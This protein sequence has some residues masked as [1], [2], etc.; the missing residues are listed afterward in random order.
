[1]TA[2]T[3]LTGRERITWNVLSSWAGHSVFIAAGFI[4]P[5][6][7]DERLGQQRLG[8]WDFAWSCVAYF[9]LVQG[10]VVSSINRYV[11][12][13]RAAGDTA[14]VNRVVS[15]VECVLTV[16]AGI[17]VILS[18]ATALLI[19][20]LWTGR[21][22][23]Y[24]VDAQWAVFLL[25]LGVALEVWTAGYAGVLTGCHRW[26]LHNGIH[27]FTC[28]LTTGGM[29]VAVLLDGGLPA[30]AAAHVLGEMV[31]RLMRV[32]LAY[33][34]FP[35]LHVRPHL[36]DWATAREMLHFGS[37]SFIP[38]IGDLL[39][40][41]TISVLILS[42]IGTAALAVFSRPR[43]LVRQV[44]TLV[45]KLAYVLAPT[46]SSLQAAARLDDLRDLFIRSTRYGVYIALPM[47]LVLTILGAPLLYVWMGQHYAYGLLLT[48][49]A[50]GGLATITQE[51]VINFL[52]GLNAHG[53]PGLANMAASLG[54]VG[55]AALAIGPLHLG[56]IGA[57]LA[58]SLPQSFV[59]GVY[60]PLVACRR[61]GLSFWD[62]L[63]QV[64][65]LPLTYCLPFALC[66]A[67]ARLVF[68][69][70]PFLAVVVGLA[71]GAPLL[72]AIYFKCV[73]PASLRNMLAGKLGRRAIQ[74]AESAA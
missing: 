31:G 3:D 35:G 69:H 61:L 70:Q 21:L 5:R 16:M 66:L 9:G 57:A 74:P 60:V 71:S 55:L 73:V 25:G 1:M 47:I 24:V 13:H 38:S 65:R 46:A 20:V 6:L 45:A 33:R 58:V 22:G 36:A 15:S 44:D 34:E 51:P 7:I 68:G 26:D 67:T 50:I 30:L 54:A 17:I 23:D 59:N 18:I 56:L 4:L 40:N 63:L 41:Q 12:R 11:A 64:W 19:P 62:Y 8:V 53:R 32:G 28:V 14:G 42:G 10:G 2:S 48:I 43:S 27:A 29:I 49:L 72:A 52:Q 39:L 37:K